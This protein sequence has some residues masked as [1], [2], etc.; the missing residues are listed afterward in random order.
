MNTEWIIVIIACI[1]LFL[2]ILVNICTIA[3]F[4]GVLR[5]NQDQQKELLKLTKEDFERRFKELK[6]ENSDHFG[7][8]E[9]KQD[10]HN[11]YIER[12]FNLER[13]DDVQDEQIKVINHRLED[14]EVNNERKLENIRQWDKTN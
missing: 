5:A 8:L 2:T 6:E 3:Y 9:K 10:I 12:T 4:A 11:H 7:R 1:T 14:L 13:R